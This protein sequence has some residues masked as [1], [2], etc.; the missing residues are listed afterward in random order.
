M[1]AKLNAEESLLLRLGR[2]EF[3]SS[4][5]PL[6]IL[7]IVLGL[8]SRGFLSA[9]NLQS[10]LQICSIYLIIGL[11]QMCTLA[12]G[13]FNLA[14]GAMGALT[15]VAVGGL[16]QVVG[17][18]LLLALPL[19]LLFSGLLGVCQGLLIAKLRVNPFIAT[20]SLLSIYTGLSYAITK[21]APFS[22]L[23][24]GIK[25]LNKLRFGFVPFS[26]VLSVLLALIMFV[27]FERLKT[28]R[29]ILMTGENNRAAAFSGIDVERMV[30]FGHGLSGILVGL[31]AMIQVSQFGSAQ[32]SVGDD[33]MM[34]SF[35]MTVLG[36][37]LL[38]GGKVSPLGTVFGSLL[39]VVINN[40][41]VLWGVNTY[42]TQAII[43]LILLLAFEV[44][45]SRGRVMKRRALQ[46]GEQKDRAGV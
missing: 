15:A 1:R 11:S 23:P 9:Y 36:G 18:P 21:G 8:T 28:G 20:L 6:I 41:L 4:L 31:A 2:L 42:A 38:S 30:V 14:I 7:S 34:P 43:G 32:V 44:D 35:V 19:A 22:D 40:A 24:E 29:R 12:L 13:Q 46:V 33:W 27:F 5:Y 45:R 39:M 17:V 3:A 25:F 10:M 37:T 16:M 26:F